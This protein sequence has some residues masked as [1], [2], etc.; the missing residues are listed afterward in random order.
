MTAI[1]D[2][3]HDRIDGARV[4]R[5]A[6]IRPDGAP[7]VV[8]ITFALDRDR[9]RLVTAV[10]HKP[11]STTELQRLVNIE[12]NPAVSVLVDHYEEDWQRLWWARADGT[13]RV[14]REGE[15]REGAVDR[16]VTKY[17]QYRHQRPAGPAVAVAIESW[18]TWS[19]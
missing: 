6:T 14:H 3:F 17:S 8:P 9:D 12:A 10:D 2:Q 11:K 19:A 1:D 4:A 16:L 13:A 18:N 15:E 5:L 7:H